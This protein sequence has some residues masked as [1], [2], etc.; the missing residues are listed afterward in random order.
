M[1]GSFN[2]KNYSLL[3]RNTFKP[4]RHRKVHG[5]YKEVLTMRHNSVIYKPFRKRMGNSENTRYY[6]DQI[7]NVYCMGS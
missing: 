1:A 2:F 7:L 4:Q 3:T 6:F 5:V